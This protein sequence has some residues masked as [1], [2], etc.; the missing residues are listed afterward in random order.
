MTRDAVTSAAMT[1]A[2]TAD[3]GRLVDIGNAS[4][5]TDAILHRE[6]KGQAEAN[7]WAARCA[8]R[9]TMLDAH[10]CPGRTAAG[11]ATPATVSGSRR[12]SS[13]SA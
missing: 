1:R 10:D 7:L 6:M 9:W 3:Q 8:A 4:S 12:R 13:A 2:A 5:R 11:K